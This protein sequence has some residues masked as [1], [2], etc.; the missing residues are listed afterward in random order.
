[1]V[2]FP[3]VS[4]IVFNFILSLKQW[5]V[6]VLWKSHIKC[7]Q[8]STKVNKSLPD[9]GVQA[10]YAAFC[11]SEN[12]AECSDNALEIFMVNVQLILSGLGPALSPFHY[13]YKFLVWPANVSGH[14]VVS[15]QMCYPASQPVAWFYGLSRHLCHWSFPLVWVKGWPEAASTAFEIFII[16]VSLFSGSMY[17]CVFVALVALLLLLF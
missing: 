13:V 10:Q 1:M 16:S 8:A 11:F 2:K 4:I 9:A 5:L 3:A 17:L 14:P 12:T 6:S 7:C 15:T